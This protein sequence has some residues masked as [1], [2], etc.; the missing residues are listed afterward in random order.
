MKVP[1]TKFKLKTIGSNDFIKVLS[2][3]ILTQTE[4]T[5]HHCLLVN[6]ESEVV[7]QKIK[8]SPIG[9]IIEVCVSQSWSLILINFGCK[10]NN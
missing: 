10:V 1:F 5:F 8:M 2:I 6:S 7:Y 9:A 4:H 3:E